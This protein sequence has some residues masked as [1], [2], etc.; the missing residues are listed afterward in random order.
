MSATELWE[1]FRAEGHGIGI[2]TVYR[3]LK[4]GVESGA[5]ASVELEAGSVRYEP[6]RLDHHHHFVCSTCDR[7][8]DLVGCVS[9]LEQLVPDGFRM[10][11]HEVLLHGT[12]SGC[13]G[14]EG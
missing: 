7:A 14:G 9:H 5:L 2:A 8:F 11:G 12:C 4:R 1:Q 6:A 10:T 3:T 13:G